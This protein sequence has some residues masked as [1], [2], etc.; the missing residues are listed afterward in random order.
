MKCIDCDYISFK[1]A[2]K[3]PLC[4]RK[5]SDSASAFLPDAV[6]G[7]T[8]FELAEPIAQA[9]ESVFAESH[10]STATAQGLS[11]PPEESTT[12]A[13]PASDFID[14]EGNFALD[15]SEAESS[16]A[17]E[18]QTAVESAVS[19][20]S[21]IPDK[22]QISLEDF[23]VEGLGFDEMSNETTLAPSSDSS[24]EEDLDIVSLVGGDASEETDTVSEP[25]LD[26]G[27]NAQDEP[28]VSVVGLDQDD[29]P[30]L[31]IEEEEEEIILSH[32][33]EPDFINLD[34]I[35]AES[36]EQQEPSLT[37][38][39]PIEETLT[40]S[41]QQEEPE[42]LDI[43]LDDVEIAI[44]SEETLELSF[45]EDDAPSPQNAQEPESSAQSDESEELEIHLELEEDQDAPL[46]TLVDQNDTVEIE[47]LGLEMEPDNGPPSPSDSEE[48]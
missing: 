9:R 18:S 42:A 5:L 14:D 26:L 25:M 41:P 24:D 3:C 47:D 45:D 13:P 4:Q 31:L 11:A 21:L 46:Q 12:P 15:L 33:E 16:D 40:L 19:L 30:L 34:D 7:F 44:E 28:D 2:K 6:E 35:E 23:E 29:E 38:S 17:P 1:I 10:P 22:Q 48:K 32:Q 43:D 39:E 27:G 20:E 36:D 8:L 37:I